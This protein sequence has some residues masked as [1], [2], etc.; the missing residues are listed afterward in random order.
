MR[1]EARDEVGARGEV[2]A[3]RG[4]GW[5]P[6]EEEGREGG[7]ERGEAVGVA[8]ELGVAAHGGVVCGNTDLEMDADHVQPFTGPGPTDRATGVDRAHRSRKGTG[9]GPT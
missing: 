1:G 3:R 9:C 8:G 4:M 7:E 2:G 6:G 5:G